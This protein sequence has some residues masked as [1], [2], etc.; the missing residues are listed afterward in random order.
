MCGCRR[1]F[2]SSWKKVLSKANKHN[3]SNKPHLMDTTA[4]GKRKLEGE[5]AN[6]ANKVARTDTTPKPAPK[7]ITKT[8]S[9]VPVKYS[10]NIPAEYERVCI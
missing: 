5:T 9:S 10:K 3:A 2:P 6:A 8:I 7:V 1:V 4:S